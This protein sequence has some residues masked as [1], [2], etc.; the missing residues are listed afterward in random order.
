MYLFAG[1][2]RIKYAGHLHFFKG[3]QDVFIMVIEDINGAR[4]YQVFSVAVRAII[5]GFDFTFA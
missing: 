2:W 3:A 4:F 1:N 5:Q